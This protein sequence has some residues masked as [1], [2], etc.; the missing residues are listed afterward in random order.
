MTPQATCSKLG[1]KSYIHP[2]TTPKTT[3]I[4]TPY[5]S[6]SPK[7]ADSLAGERGEDPH[8][9]GQ[10]ERE[11]G[12]S[13]N[14]GEKGDEGV[15]KKGTAEEGG[16]ERRIKGQEEM[17][18]VNLLRFLLQCSSGQMQIQGNPGVRVFARHLSVSIETKNSCI[19]NHLS[20]F[21]AV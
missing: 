6:K 10:E 5:G 15:K 8:R 3:V 18:T 9:K 12:S 17:R 16:G 1:S 21:I 4:H 20:N 14:R 19:N 11:Q 7:Y 2:H 13:R